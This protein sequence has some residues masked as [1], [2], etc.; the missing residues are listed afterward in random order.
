MLSKVGIGDDVIGWLC[1]SLE[2]DGD[3]YLRNPIL[4]F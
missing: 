4:R 2:G 3:N 1:L